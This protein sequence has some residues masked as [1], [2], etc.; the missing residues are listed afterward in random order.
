MPSGKT[1]PKES[2]KTMSDELD[3]KYR[4]KTFKEVRGQ[5]PAVSVLQRLLSSGKMPHRL[6]FTGPSGCGKTTLTRIVRVKLEC[7]KRDFIEINCADF[8]GID[9]VR[10]IRRQITQCPMGG[11]SRVWLIDECHKLTN[12]AQTA[13]LK[14]IEEPPSH[15]Y[16]FLATTD[17]QKL[18]P[19]MRSRCTV[20]PLQLLDA[21]AMRE[22]I[23]RA[24]E[25]EG[26]EL[27]SKVKDRLV[28]A[29]N[30]SARKALV[31]LQTILG[32]DD[33]KKQLAIIQDADIEN[34][35][36]EIAR[37]LMNPSTQWPTMTKILKGLGKD[38][39]AE[40]IRRLILAYATSCILG[41]NVRSHKA[42]YLLLV[43]FAEPYYDIGRPGLVSS[44]Y[45]VITKPR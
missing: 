12:D 24:L 39:D 7:S 22:T 33:V 16:F 40:G 1:N 9:M 14:M 5:G 23:D 44:C 45:E 13:M 11:K 27:S 30:G 35:A 42:A 15:V 34:Q 31:T 29:S 38:E 6:L 10:D 4:P 18:I 3:R 19:T 8:R 26:A 32:E 43:A 17:P 36:I 2:F 21:T 28:T 37:A 20:I 41:D 25:G